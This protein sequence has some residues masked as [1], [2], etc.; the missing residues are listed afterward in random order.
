M[1]SSPDIYENG[2]PE[3]VEWE[4][5][6]IVLD[7]T[8]L[9]KERIPTK[10]QTPNFELVSLE[11][12]GYNFAIKFVDWKSGSKKNDI[13]LVWQVWGRSPAVVCHHRELQQLLNRHCRFFPSTCQKKGQLERVSKVLKLPR[14]ICT[15]LLD[16]DICVLFIYIRA[17]F[18]IIQYWLAHIHT[19]RLTH[20]RLAVQ[21]M[22]CGRVYEVKCCNWWICQKCSAD[23]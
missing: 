14:H 13:G 17:P 21:K 4:L 12:R 7:L 6:Q 15:P 19:W 1:N 2:R 3:L 16:V 11:S 10:I 8:F 18:F 22:H 20:W 9:K 5:F 23:I